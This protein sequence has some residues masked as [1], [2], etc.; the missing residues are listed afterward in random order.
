MIKVCE[1]ALFAQ[2]SEPIAWATDSPHD[3]STTFVFDRKC[4]CVSMKSR[5][6]HSRVEPLDLQPETA[7]RIDA[8]GQERGG[9]GYKL[10]SSVV[11]S[12]GRGRAV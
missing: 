9:F 2:G 7:Q 11:D 10:S 1:R 5:I 4:Y 8:D 3:A 6:G 12:R